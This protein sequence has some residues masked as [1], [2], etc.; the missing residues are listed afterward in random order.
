MKFGIF[1][2]HEPNVF[3]KLIIESHRSL[4]DCCVKG[5]MMALTLKITVNSK[6][7]TS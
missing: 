3:A 6:Q 1:L 5:G 4:I 7:M 2:K